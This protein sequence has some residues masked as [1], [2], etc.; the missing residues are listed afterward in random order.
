MNKGDWFIEE[1][2]GQAGALSFKVDEVLFEGESPYQKVKI[3]KNSF[4][5]NVMLLDDLVMVTDKDEFFYHD[6]LVHVPMV[7]VDNPENVLIIGGG[8]GGSV[9]EVLKHQGVK[10]V[11]LCEI[12]KMVIDVARK[13]FPDLS[14]CLDDKRVEVMVADGIKYIKE[15]KNEFD[16]ICVDSTDPIGPAVGLFTPEFYGYVKDAL[17]V[18]G[19]MS[20]QTESPSWTLERVVGIRKNI[21]AAFGNAYL[22]LCP[23]P[24]Y[25]SGLWSFALGMKSDKDP[26]KDFNI[27]RSQIVAKQCK[28][29]NPEIH[30]AAFCLPNF[31]RDALK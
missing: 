1:F 26:V 12:D 11:V 28:Y 31:I 7:C 9:R 27:E 24:C 17:R 21:E 18:G 8:D 23:I 30:K 29:Y 15:H 19:V 5:G 3:V 14:N 20:A 13:Y 16:C 10:R 25:P 4:F 22:Y 2:Q 6:M